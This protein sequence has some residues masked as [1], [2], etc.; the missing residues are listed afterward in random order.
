MTRREFL[1]RMGLLGLTVV[2]PKL[3]F[4][5]GANVNKYTELISESSIS[6][7]W[8]YVSTSSYKRVHTSISGYQ[9]DCAGGYIQV[10]PM[11]KTPVS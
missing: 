4:D 11:T 5:Y 3:I 10:S 9:I 8:R 2:A 1:Q 6:S 7:E